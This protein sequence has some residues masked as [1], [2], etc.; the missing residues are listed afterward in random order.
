M[1]DDIS[2]M[3][4]DTASEAVERPQFRYDPKGGEVDSEGRAVAYVAHL[5]QVMP[6]LVPMLEGLEDNI[7]FSELAPHVDGMTMEGDEVLIYGEALLGVNLEGVEKNDQGDVYLASLLKRDGRS[8]ASEEK[9]P[10]RALDDIG[11]LEPYKLSG[12]G[13]RI[14]IGLGISERSVVDTYFAGDE[15]AF[16]DSVRDVTGHIDQMFNDVIYEM[17]TDGLTGA[18]VRIK[19]IRND[20]RQK[21]P[22]HTFEKQRQYVKDNLGVAEEL[23]DANVVRAKNGSI[24]YRATIQA[25]CDL[26]F[27]ELPKDV[28]DKLSQFVK[29]KNTRYQT[30]S[31]EFILRLNESTQQLGNVIER[32]NASTAERMPEEAGPERLEALAMGQGRLVFDAGKDLMTDDEFSERYQMTF[33]DKVGQREPTYLQKVMEGGIREGLV[34][35]I[36]DAPEDASDDAASLN[37]ELEEIVDTKGRKTKT[38]VWAYNKTA[39]EGQEGGEVERDVFAT[40]IAKN[41]ATLP[42]F[43]ALVED[44]KDKL[45]KDYRARAGEHDVMTAP[46]H[47]ATHGSLAV[48]TQAL[49]N[50]LREIYNRRKAIILPQ[51]E[52]IKPEADKADE[53]IAGLMAEMNATLAEFERTKSKS[54]AKKGK[55]LTEALARKFEE[56]GQMIDARDR[57]ERMKANLLGFGT[58]SDW[59]R[60]GLM[61]DE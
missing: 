14:R 52:R 33:E 23:V 57:L 5:R 21:G 34:G 47:Y 58:V 4:E 32:A 20:N 44:L 29:S 10:E 1:T 27:N 37:L 46:E 30:L 55:A 60:E 9:E 36:M 39:R 18:E 24:N 25:I 42:G 41:I 2:D 38:L 59:D 13:G 15:D 3:L 17:V 35:G 26:K 31:T 51:Y 54:L 11:S 19:R 43:R 28:R 45:M 53:E 61:E 22:K 56:S 6:H 16:R 12:E 40:R 8:Y 48:L 50:T 49:E 7:P